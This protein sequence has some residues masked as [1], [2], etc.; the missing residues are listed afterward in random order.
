MVIQDEV[1]MENKISG[2]QGALIISCSGENGDYRDGG[3]LWLLLP[4]LG[5]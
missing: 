4:A 1:Q 3:M 5:N 2:D